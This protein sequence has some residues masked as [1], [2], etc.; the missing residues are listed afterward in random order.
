MIHI[1]FGASNMDCAL[2]SIGCLEK[3]TERVYVSW[4][5]R[6][7]LKGCQSAGFGKSLVGEICGSPLR[8]DGGRKLG[9]RDSVAALLPGSRACE[10]SLD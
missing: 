2:Q 8:S 5:Y 7:A 4:T 1:L 10:M 3:S 9:L 6:F